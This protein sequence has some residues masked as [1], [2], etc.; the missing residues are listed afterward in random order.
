M[1]TRKIIC[2]L[3]CSALMQVLCQGQTPTYPW[4]S[5]DQSYTPPSPNAQAF[6]S[7]GNEPVAM[8]TGTPA[9]DIPIYV[10][11]CG[12][13]TVPI[14]L[15]YNYNGFNP[16]QDAGWVGLGW[17]INAG[18]AIS[19]IVEGKVDS[20][21]HTGYNYGD[22][23]LTD[24]L[25][26]GP[27]LD[28]FL[29][30]AYNT[31]LY[32]L[33]KS[34]DMAPDI[35]DAEFNGYSGKFF[36]VKGKSYLLSYDKQL[37]IDYAYG[38]PYHV[39]GYNITTDNGTQYFFGLTEWTTSYLYGG[40]DSIIQGYNSAWVLTQMV[41]A[42]TKDTVN[43]NYSEYSWEQA[44]ASY[45]SSYTMTMGTQGSMGY[46]QTT[47]KVN[48]SITS[49]ILQSITCR[50]SRVVF[51]P[52]GSSRTD[53][54][55]NYPCL[56][57]IDVI[58][59]LTG[60]TIK[61]NT[62]G[63]E[64]F[65]QTS[66]SPALY[67]RLG[68]K[69]FNSVNPQLSSDTLTYTFKYLDEFTNPYPAKGTY[70]V[71]YW[72]YYN[73]ATG[74]PN[75]LPSGS[76]PY[77]GSPAPSG[78]GFT[79][80]RVPGFTNCSFAALDTIFYP[81]GGY[82]AFQYA[83]NTYYDATL[84]TLPGPGIRL[85][86]SS[87]V[88]N[89]PLNT[90]ATTK[91][92][93]YL[94]DDGVTTSGA[95]TAAP[96]F[97][98][99]PFILVQN[100]TTYIYN[101]YQA[102][103][104]SDGIGGINPKFYYKKVTET[105]NSGPEIHK[106]D[107][108]FTSFP[109]IFLDVR[110][111]TR[112]DYINTGGTNFIPVKSSS[113]SYLTTGSM[114][115]TLAYAYPYIDTEYAS[116]THNPHIWYAYNFYLAYW[117]TYWIHPNYQQTTEYDNQGNSINTVT[118]FNYDSV[119]N[120]LSST[121]TQNLSDGQSLI[122]KFKY[123]EDYSSSLTGNMV[124]ARVLSPPIESQTWLYKSGS[125]S[126]MISGNVTQFD[127]SSFKP[128]S[129]YS[130]ETTKPITSLN[131]ETFSSG[132]FT[133]ILSDSRYVLKGQLQYD[134]NNNLSTSTKSAD[135]NI[136][137]IWDYRHSNPIAQ[138]KNASQTDIAYTSFEA[139]GKGNWSFTGS[140]TS[141]TTS[142]TGSKCYNV[143]Q[144]SGSVTKSALTSATSYIVS[145]WIKGST[146]LSITGTVSGYPVKGKTINGWTYFEHKVTGQTTITVSGSG[147]NYIDELR[148]YPSNAQMMTYTY[149]PL[150]G[151]SSQCDADNRITYYKYDPFTRLNVVLDQDH[152]IIKTVHYH[153]IGET[154]E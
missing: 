8:Y 92:Y 124:N 145:Y 45:Q 18:G 15:S 50:N 127:Q 4:S 139:D 99:A 75:F 116:S 51:L 43:F 119:S 79:S 104:N 115:T 120:N 103:N 38:G 10:V 12:S 146:A 76:S 19:R 147:T 136:S 33:N 58:D 142:P 82:T 39:L 28:S 150:V 154:N 29:Q 122:R 133:S 89:N 97:T 13:L 31:N 72:G 40:N 26:H 98:G 117:N 37:K 102:P 21:Q 74:N 132:R 17:N 94:L 105:I 118:Y 53:V 55:G 48:P 129:S 114:D 64:Y 149:A 41:S 24:S 107:N 61:K 125:D 2:L 22:Y 87:T 70:A 83:G 52:D 134:G 93:N 35:F 106:T 137:Y 54:I 68:L 128:V 5:V 86:S 20:S 65:G 27:A 71:D 62:F 135:M 36:R 111:T 90:Q 34:Y 11:K 25:F 59:S 7:Y 32:H 42:D 151:I 3:I 152:N 78:A 95:L 84:G 30:T 138:V 141:D 88:S 112:N 100:G 57:E 80:N 6:Q 85:Q 143:G 49:E 113:T 140:V 16:L 67:E 81:A 73:G 56:K 14:S 91:T 110:E 63:Y 77:Y 60:T 23:S 46:D 1:N 126:V 9:I 69:W 109:G 153:Y 144:T 148:L 130:I 44:Q 66:T 101:T 47:Y 121:I 96:S 131:H 123:P 108:Y